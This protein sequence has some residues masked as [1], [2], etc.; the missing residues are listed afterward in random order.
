Q[1]GYDYLCDTARRVCTQPRDCLAWAKV[2][3]GGLAYYGGFL[4]ATGYAYYYTRKHRLSF[5]RVADLAAPAIMLGLFFGRMGCYLN[6]C[7]Y[8]KETGSPLGV[9]F[10]RGSSAWRAQFD[11]G[12]ISLGVMAHAVHPTQL[13]EALAC[14]AISAFLYLIVR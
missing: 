10:P 3:R 7:S 1:C 5:W 11:A 14:L 2:W 6:G 12:R 13:Y 9:V 4:L 8:G